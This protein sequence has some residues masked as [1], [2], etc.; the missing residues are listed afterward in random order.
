MKRFVLENSLS[1]FF[2]TIFLAS[3]LGQSFAGQRAYNAD[4]QAHRGDS[5]SWLNYVLSPT[6]AGR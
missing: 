2:A 5:V 4:Q 1:L 6:S 3:V